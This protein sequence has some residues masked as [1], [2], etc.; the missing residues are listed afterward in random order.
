M[1]GSPIVSVVKTG[2]VLQGKGVSEG[3][4]VLLSKPVPND[5]QCTIIL[6]H[7]P[8][9]PHHPYVVWTYNEHTGG[10]HTGDYYD[11]QSEAAVRFAERTW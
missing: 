1:S 3:A 2:V 4:T 7:A 8:Q 10:C 9:S 6:C 11:S 5:P